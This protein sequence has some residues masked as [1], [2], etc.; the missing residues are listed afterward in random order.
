MKSYINKLPVNQQFSKIADFIWNISRA[1]NRW[2]VHLTSVIIEERGR[3]KK[4]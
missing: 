2:K 3:I 4:L 1:I